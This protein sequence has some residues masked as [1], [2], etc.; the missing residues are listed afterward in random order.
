[1]RIAITGASGMVGTALTPFLES[2]GHD[3]VPV[4][5]RPL[6][7]GITWHPD[8]NEIDADAF[9]GIDAVVHLAGESIAGARWTSERKRALRD[10]RVGP[11]ALLSRTLAALKRPPQVLVSAS[12]VGIYGDTGGAVVDESAPHAPDFLG[13][14]AAEWEAAADPARTA[15]IRVAHP[16]LATILSPTGG[17]LEK[18]LPPFRL[19]VGGP[20]A[21]GRHWMP[22]VA[23]DDV[24]RAIMFMIDRRD[25][26]G[27]ANV[28][29]PGLVTNAE[30][31]RALGEVIHRPAVMPV[32]RFVLRA[33]YGELADAALL[34]S[35]R[36]VPRKL[37][38]H[39]FVFA[40][41]QVAA[42]LRHVLGD[43]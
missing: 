28:A 32:P 12:G 2:L 27:P 18:M 26:E 41:P 22:W 15:G 37:E 11:T 34:A 38:S 4:S 33:L 30:F 23:L 13:G 17:A 35:T 10:S 5:R 40:F 29:A 3:V 6:P 21:G 19:G 36:A 43:G 7:G 42:A 16:R 8:R 24:L 25:L 9:E 31:T 1:M 14:L 20:L 39:G